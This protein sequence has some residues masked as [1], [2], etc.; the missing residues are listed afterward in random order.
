MMQ[1][2]FAVQPVEKNAKEISD[3][4][5]ASEDAIECALKMVEMEFFNVTIAT[6]DHNE[7]SEFLSQ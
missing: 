1:F 2:R 5:F 4:T 7:D 3:V 6:D